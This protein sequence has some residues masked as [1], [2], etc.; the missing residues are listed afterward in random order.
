MRAVFL[1][2]PPLLDMVLASCCA[3][4]WVLAVMH[5]LAC[6][7]PNLSADV[8][9]STAASH[10]AATGEDQRVRKFVVFRRLSS[11]RRH[12]ASWH[13]VRPLAESLGM[14][15]HCRAA[16]DTCGQGTRRLAMLD[17]VHTTITL[18]DGRILNLIQY[19]MLL[20]VSGVADGCLPADPKEVA[21]LLAD[22]VGKALT[23]PR[24]ESVV[25]ALIT[26]AAAYAGTCSERRVYRLFARPTS[27]VLAQT[28]LIREVSKPPR[29][30]TTGAAD[31]SLARVVRARTAILQ[32]IKR[33]GK[34]Q[35]VT[36]ADLLRRVEETGSTPIPCA[37]CEPLF[38]NDRCPKC[39]SLAH[40]EIIQAIQHHCDTGCMT[41]ARDPTLG[42]VYARLN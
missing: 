36:L 27:N 21:D 3:R 17:P 33:A 34:N 7:Q 26:T 39:Q 4:P 8:R 13:L 19:W 16:L 9:L 42:V 31:Y 40:G 5:L 25:R 6:T 29:T 15:A 14:V 28:R 41:E 32:S 18:A 2:D 23:S 37:A 24:E 12:P 1:A 20:N 22:A 10:I 35:F 38:V 30:A 11:Y